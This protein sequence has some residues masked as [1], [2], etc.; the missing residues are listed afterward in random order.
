MTAATAT[1]MAAATATSMAAATAAAAPSAA[2]R[3][4]P[5]V[6]LKFCFSVKNVKSPQ[7]NVR[8]FL[9]GENDPRSGARR[10]LHSGCIR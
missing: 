8:H 4:K 3:C 9:L 2:T 10:H 1:S 7:A 6:G 5:Y